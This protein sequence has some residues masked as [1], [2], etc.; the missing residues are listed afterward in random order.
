LRKVT[1]TGLLIALGLSFA[2]AQDDRPTVSVI[3]LRA[4]EGVTE[5]EAQI[6]TDRL[7]S[8]IAATDVYRIV[9]RSERNARLEQLGYEMSGACDDATCVAE[10]G[11]ELGVEKMISGSIGRLGQTWTVMVQLVDVE[12]ALTEN[13]VHNDYKGEIDELL[14]VMAV[15]AAELVGREVRVRPPRISEEPS[16][17]PGPILPCGADDIVVANAEVIS[18]EYRY[19]KQYARQGRYSSRRDGG[20]VYEDGTVAGVWN[21]GI[22][23]LLYYGFKEGSLEVFKVQEGNTTISLRLGDIW[24]DGV[25]AFKGD[26]GYASVEPS[27]RFLAFA[28]GWGRGPQR[29]YLW[30]LQTER[31]ILLGRG[32]TPRF[33]FENDRLYLLVYEW[34]DEKETTYRLEL[35]CRE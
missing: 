19:D 3:D 2:L 15:V 13:P 23:Y 8:E 25:K 28:D 14:G 17:A 27:L 35:G 9:N 30:D 5:G 11:R 29:V 32:R 6:L 1:L 10:I 4:L 24:L 12:T 34:N 20:F 21:G 16:S 18:R 31:P 26:V 33:V 7:M 22:G